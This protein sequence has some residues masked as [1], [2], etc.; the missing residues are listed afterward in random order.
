[1]AA[2]PPAALAPRV[3]VW[4]EVGGRYAFGLGVADILQAI[5]RAGAIKQAAADLG[6][7][8]RHVWGRVKEAEA[9]LGRPLVDSRVGGRGPR[10]SALT[11]EARRLVAAFLR[12]RRRVHQFLPRE[13]SRC[14]A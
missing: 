14:F 5:D 7:S 3:K 8:Y 1:M 10:R 12:L 4:L 9:A 6:K 13:F 11:P 2:P